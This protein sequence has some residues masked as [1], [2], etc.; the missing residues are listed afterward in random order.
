MH[1]H[2]HV[3]TGAQAR[4][5][6]QTQGH[7]HTQAHAPRLLTDMEDV[8]LTFPSSTAHCGANTGQQWDSPRP[9]SL[10]TWTRPHAA[11]DGLGGLG[12]QLGYLVPQGGGPALG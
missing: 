12:S 4:T 3:R 11:E 7:T 1:A 5:H 10:S 6:M 2:T 9:G 8:P